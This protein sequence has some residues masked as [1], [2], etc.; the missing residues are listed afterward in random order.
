MAPAKTKKEIVYSDS[1]S[2]YESEFEDDDI[3]DED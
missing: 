1:E 2:D 3:E